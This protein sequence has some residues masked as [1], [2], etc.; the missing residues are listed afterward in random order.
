M[1]PIS[2]NQTEHLVRDIMT[3]PV[4]T[5]D[6]DDSIL[7]VKRLFDR[8]KCHHVVILKNRRAYG[9][10]SD[11]DILQVLSPFVGSK[12]MERSQDINTLSKRVHQ[13]MS[14]DLITVSPNETMAAAA[15]KMLKNRVSCLPVLDKSGSAVGIVTVR[16]FVKWSANPEGANHS[17]SGALEPDDG[18]FIIIDGSRC[19]SPDAK[20]AQMIREAEKLCDVKNEPGSAKAKRLPM[21]SPAAASK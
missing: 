20:M 9:V 3:A 18:I 4:I 19:Y 6:M 2:E 16:D 1:Q 11:R 8:E 7:T 21:P 13:V 10:V 5:V 17:H 14:R 15:E 12:M